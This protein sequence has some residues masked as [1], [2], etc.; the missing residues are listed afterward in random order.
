MDLPPEIQA[1]IDRYQPSWRPEA[2]ALE[3]LVVNIAAAGGGARDADQRRSDDFALQTAAVL[4][5]YVQWAGGTPRM[6]RA[7]DQPAA[8]NSS[9][10]LPDADVGVRVACSPI[11]TAQ[12][13][14]AHSYITAI[15][16]DGTSQPLIQALLETFANN[17]QPGPIAPNGG[18]PEARITL[19]LAG[20]GAVDACPPTLPRAIATKICAGLIAWA[21]RNALTGKAARPS[22]RKD[23]TPVPQFYDR[24]EDAEIAGV[25]RRIW[26]HGDLPADRAAWFC[27][28][29]CSVGLSDRSFVHFQ[30]NVRLEKNNIIIGGTTNLAVMRDT[31]PRALACV[32]LAE[33]NNKMRLLPEEGRLG[34]ERFGICVAS[35]ALT[36]AQPTETS[37]LRSQLLYGEPLYLLDREDGFMLVHGDDG[38]WGWVREECVRPLPAGAFAEL[39]T[40]KRAVLV[41]DLD[42]RDRRLVR[43]TSLPF[44]FSADSRVILKDPVGDSFEVSAADVRAFESGPERL[45]RVERALA[46]LH[47]PYVYGAV[48][49]IGLDCSGLVQTLGDQTGVN[50]PRD[51]YQ[52][53]LS[54]RLAATRWHPA[55]VRTGDLLYF[56]NP[57][58]RI[59]HVAIA[60]TETHFVHSG[61]PEVK[62]NS[63]HPGDRLFSADR[64]R[65]FLAA[66]RV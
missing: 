57:C 14:D 11:P 9:A 5:H 65:T 53:F 33:V 21:N 30:P 55:G 20:A 43:G 38:Y 51:A 59:F 52:Q 66:R 50:L 4:F 60:L 46:M 24:S 42:L 6:A 32:G 25:A 13:S 37:G 26:P 34:S 22:R 39:A 62:I 45:E 16:I 17:C 44:E 58:G 61:P 29:W 48:S 7:D 10:L 63:L 19:A 31:L 27:D 54:G 36:Y 1:A 56:I 41:R 18:P 64:Q 40:A 2:G 3:N 49:P 28:M 47:R 35:M 8:P 15:Q 12:E 23:A